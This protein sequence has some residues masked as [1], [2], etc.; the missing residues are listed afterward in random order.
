MSQPEVLAAYE[1]EHR[2]PF[3]LFCDPKRDAYRCFGLTRA[4]AQSFLRPT[5]IAGY[6]RL[7]IRG[8]KPRAIQRGEDPFQLG[9][10][11]IVDEK[12]RVVYSYRSRVATDRPEVKKLIDMLR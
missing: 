12:Q 3:P 5:V 1:R 11:F 6:V 4:S 9:G 2:F 8:W 10:D 7:M